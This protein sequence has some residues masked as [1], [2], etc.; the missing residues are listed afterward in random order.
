M[1]NTEN[2]IL[3]A[4]IQTVWNCHVKSLEVTALC[5]EGRRYAL[6]KIDIN[7]DT[8]VVT[9]VY[10]NEIVWTYRMT[11]CNKEYTTSYELKREESPVTHSIVVTGEISL[12]RI[13]TSA[14]TQLKWTTKCHVDT[15][16]GVRED[17]MQLKREVF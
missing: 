10:E 13:S 5:P 7:P 6:E 14:H 17:I 2:V 15:E 11:E 8:G 16:Q 12:D 9:M 3:P 1:V 4:S